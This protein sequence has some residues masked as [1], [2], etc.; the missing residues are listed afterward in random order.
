MYQKNFEDKNPS[1]PS[2]FLPNELLIKQ[3]ILSEGELTFIFSC[4]LLSL[5]FL[6]NNFE[7]NIFFRATARREMGGA[8]RLG[9]FQTLL[10]RYLNF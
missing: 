4:Q 5:P 10:K 1:I 7:K 9:N 6:F 8:C 3:N 2:F